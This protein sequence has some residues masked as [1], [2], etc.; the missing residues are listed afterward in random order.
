MARLVP[1]SSKESVAGIDWNR[2]IGGLT[3]FP[4][5]HSPWLNKLNQFNGD[6]IKAEMS[7]AFIS[8]SEYRQWFGP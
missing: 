7:K 2:K 3:L 8:S 6:Y 4:R 5:F 1:G